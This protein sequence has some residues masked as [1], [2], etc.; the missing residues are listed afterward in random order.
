MN[1]ALK[2]LELKFTTLEFYSN[3]VISRVHE[4]LVFSNEHVQELKNSLY[5]VF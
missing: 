3:Y 1:K 2:T 5:R 4:D